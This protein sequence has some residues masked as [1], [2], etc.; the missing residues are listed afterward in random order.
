M[1][2]KYK[3][4]TKKLYRIAGELI[5]TCSH[6]LPSGSVFFTY[7]NGARPRALETYTRGRIAKKKSS[8]M[9]FFILFKKENLVQCSEIVLKLIKSELP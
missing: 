7:A 2:H 1:K 4:T 3:T 9:F 6:F 8:E 5:S